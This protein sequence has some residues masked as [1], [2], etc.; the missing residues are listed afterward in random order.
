M[1]P[2]RNTRNAVQRKRD[3]ELPLTVDE[4]RFSCTACGLCCYGSLPL[5][6]DEALAKAGRFP[7]A[8]SVTP[9][10]VGSRGQRSIGSMAAKV[11]LAN[12]KE[13]SVIVS[14]ISFIPPSLPCPE[15]STDNLCSIQEN[16]PLRCRAMPFIPTRDEDQQAT[17][18]VPRSGWR[19]ATDTSAAIV[20]QGGKILNPTDYNNERA[21]LVQGAPFLQRYID[22]LIGIDK[23]FHARLMKTVQATVPGRVI[24][25]FAS[26][27]RVNKKYD[28]RE[29]ADRQIPVLEY[30]LDRTSAAPG[31]AQHHSY[32]KEAL[33]DLTRYQPT[34]VNQGR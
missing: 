32:Y 18:L 30:W 33:A 12:R 17:M 3:R 6:F 25:G 20:Y 7:L 19:C 14:P 4:H 9:V 13:I 5:T 16:K 27:L 11:R 1:G 29:F 21:A 8:I 2:G 26:M 23:A 24:V 28:L 22:L 31:S 34:P 10:K 15:L